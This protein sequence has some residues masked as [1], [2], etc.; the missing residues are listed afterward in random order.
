MYVLYTCELLN[1]FKRCLRAYYV[2]RQYNNLLFMCMYICMYQCN[3]YIYTYI[4]TYI[5]IYAHIHIQIHMHIAHTY[6]GLWIV[7]MQH[8]VAYTHIAVTDTSTHSML[9][10]LGQCMC[11]TCTHAHTCT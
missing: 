7:Y 2:T 8:T 3:I 9:Q 11:N 10:G 6:A 1:R 4:Y 5:Y